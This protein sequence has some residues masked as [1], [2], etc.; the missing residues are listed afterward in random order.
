MAASPDWSWVAQ[1]AIG[2]SGVVLCALGCIVS[3][4]LWDLRRGVEGVRSEVMDVRKEITRVTGDAAVALAKADALRSELDWRVRVSEHDHSLFVSRLE[5]EKMIREAWDTL[6][7][8]ARR[9]E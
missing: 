6:S 9:S 5:V 7:M 4:M 3:A 2:V 8:R 1:W